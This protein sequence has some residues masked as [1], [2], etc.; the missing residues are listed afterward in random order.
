MKIGVVGAGKMGRGV[1]EYL[2]EF[3]IHTYLIDTNKVI[4]QE[5]LYEIKNIYRFS[6]NRIKG[7]CKQNI[8]ENL[9]LSTDK[10]VLADAH[11][12]IECIT[13][14]VTSKRILYEELSEICSGDAIFITNTSC[15]PVTK[16]ASYASK[17]ERV[18]GIHFM[19][20]VDK[21]ETVELIKGRKTSDT[22]MKYVRDFLSDI[23]KRYIEIEDAAGFVSNRISHLFMNEAIWI[24]YEGY[25]KADDIDSVFK[26]CY[27]HKMGPLE[28]ADLIGLDTVKASLEILYQEYQDTKFRCCPLLAR[29]VEAGELGRKSGKGFYEY[30]INF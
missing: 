1:S 30:T 8:D 16:I 27:G 9:I 3:G 18:V 17:S 23:G 11:L 28:T 15:I 10:N 20:P 5:A 2:L 7:K 19:N 6:K 13:E 12:I 21:I 29:M 14:N 4:L 22:T 24:L 26:E 25:A